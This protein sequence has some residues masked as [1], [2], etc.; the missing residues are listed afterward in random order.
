[1]ALRH[2]C[3]L[4]P[5]MS[6]LPAILLLLVSGGLQFEDPSLKG[7]PVAFDYPAIPQRYW[8]EWQTE[9]RFCGKG[10]PMVDRGSGMTIGRKSIDGV[11][12]LAAYGYTDFPA[13]ILEIGDDRYPVRRIE[14]EVSTDNMSLKTWDDES[15]QSLVLQRCPVRAVTRDE[16]LPWLVKASA[17]CKV[18]DTTAF[19]EAFFASEAV[20][21]SSL[22]RYVKV[23][24]AGRSY[25]LDRQYY[26]PPSIVQT[27]EGYAIDDT[28]Q[29]SPTPVAIKIVSL[30]NERFR[31][32]WQRL[33]ISEIRGEAGQDE[34]TSEPYGPS[35]HLNFKMKKGC[36]QLVSE[37]SDYRT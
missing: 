30:S 17:A 31:A 35:H 23:R 12:L 27:A 9:R 13:T 21:R 4:M 11:K 7:S 8:G 36:W 24:E 19:I 33:Q 20:Q 18:G 5:M 25:V 34:I 22:A 16:D 32:S 14:L 3:A 6:L 26:R 29:D 1:M 15:G 37:E 28:R 2:D 10:G